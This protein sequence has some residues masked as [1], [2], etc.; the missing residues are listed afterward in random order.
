MTKSVVF[1]GFL[2]RLGSVVASWPS[3]SFMKIL[4]IK[5]LSD[6]FLFGLKVLLVLSLVNT[7]SRKARRQM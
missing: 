6:L 1:R 2:Y 7:S 5:N 3:R 4:Q